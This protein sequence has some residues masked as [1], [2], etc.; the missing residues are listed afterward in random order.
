MWKVNVNALKGGGG[1]EWKIVK[2][3]L[4]IRFYKIYYEKLPKRSLSSKISEFEACRFLNLLV[5][6]CAV[7][8]FSISTWCKH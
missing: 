2:I 5:L 3:T 8:L 1:N 6:K 4:V 7:L